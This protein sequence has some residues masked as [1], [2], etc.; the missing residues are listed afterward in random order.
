MKTIQDIAVNKINTMV[1]D[2]TL[3]KAVEDSIEKAVLS[4][5]NRQ[6]ESYGAIT[7]QIEKAIEEG[8][9]LA[10][11]E[12]PF[13]TYNQ[14]MLVYVKARLGD[15]FG[16]A[17]SEKFISEIDKAL[18]PAPDTITI[19]EFIETIIEHWKIDEPWDADDL[20]EYATVDIE[21]KYG[22]TSFSLKMW[23]QKTTSCGS[24]SQPDLHLY[25]ID[26]ALRINHKHSYNPTCFNEVEAFIFKLYAAN[27]IITDIE[28]FNEDDVDLCIKEEEY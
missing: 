13:E 25:I 5:V 7:K 24:N 6:F 22:A 19:N 16:G 18:A 21:N 26:G 23:K 28:D 9:Q 4:A 15:M 20:D 11:K 3:Q 27:T 8:L 17:A 14:Q 2:G 1:E 12:L 10:L